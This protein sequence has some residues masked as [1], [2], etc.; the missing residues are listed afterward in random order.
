MR[1]CWQITKRIGDDEMRLVKS[2]VALF[3]YNRPELTVRTLSAVKGY[4][5]D[6]L[7]IFSDG[8]KNSASDQFSVEATRQLCRDI[9]WPCQVIR[10]QA[11]KNLGRR[12]SICNGLDKIFEHVDTCIILEDDCLPDPTFFVFCEQ[13]LNQYR[14][15]ASVMCIGGYKPDGI[16]VRTDVSYHFSKYPG[17]WGWATWKRAYVGFDPK[18]RGWSQKR[19]Y[20]WLTHH[21][22]AET[23]GRYW[24]YMFDDAQ[25][26]GDHWD[27]AWAYHCWKQN[28]LAI[29]A[30]HNLIQNTGFGPDATHT[31]D[32][33][34]PFGL[35]VPEP[36]RFP[37]HHPL[38]VKEDDD[39]DAQLE[40]LLYSGMRRRQ[41]DIARATIRQQRFCYI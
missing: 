11:E 29:R 4:R 33:S 25:R 37:M 22:G 2:P 32:P 5:P 40:G 20:L 23:Y 10:F 21:L 24:A 36:M 31:K 26:G 3:M 34:H 19:D 12:G 7:F 17:T 15:D 27:Y 38:I 13:L 6:I 14:E 8:P 1:L 39:I 9:D 41:L 35:V 18:L 16:K 30:T 28:G